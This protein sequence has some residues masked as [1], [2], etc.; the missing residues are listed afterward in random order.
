MFS[1]SFLSNKFGFVY[2]HNYLSDVKVNELINVM[3][4]NKGEQIT[5][6]ETKISD[7][8]GDLGKAVSFSAG[9]MGFFAL[10][11]IQGI[12]KGDEVILQGHTCSVM[13]NAVWRT[14]AT[15]VFADIDPNTYNLDPTSIENLSAYDAILVPGGFGS[16]G[17]EGIVMAITYAR[18]HKVPYFGLCYG[19]QLACVEFARNIMGKST[20]NTIEVDPNTSDPIIILNPNQAK[21][22]REEKYGATMRLGAYDCT[23]VSGSKSF[24]AYGIEDISER[25]RHRYEFNNVYKDAMHAAGLEI[26]G[27]NTES[28]L[29]EIV[30]LKDHPFFVGVQF[31]PEFKSRP[32]SPHPSFLA[33]VQAGMSS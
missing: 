30:E 24:E 3:Q 14:G 2:G 21:N 5:K 11:Q 22:I 6:F 25:H 13:P 1:F 33:F 18:E 12:G 31:H 17:I 27:M 15:P 32:L 10:M 20:A 16:R 8:I 7:N 28:D 9:R 29:V 23:L 26:V 19:M 4:T